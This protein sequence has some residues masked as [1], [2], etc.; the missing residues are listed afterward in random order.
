VTLVMLWLEG[1]SR[2]AWMVSDSRLS[3]PGSAGGRV[4]YT[5]RAAKILEASIVLWPLEPGLPPIAT[6]KLGF[7][8]CG[9][10]LVALNA[11]AA[12]LPLW[13]NLR[14]ST[15]NL[16]PSV[17][18]CAEHLAKFVGAYAREVGGSGTGDPTTQCVLLGYDT[19]RHRPECWCVRT[20][21]GRDGLTSEVEQV[22]LSPRRVQTFGS[23]A[24]RADAALASLPR[25]ALWGREPLR[26]IRGALNRDDQGDVGGGVQIGMAGPD[27]FELLFD[28]QPTV[29]T[30]FGSSPYAFRYRGFELDD[31]SR[32][33][34]T[35]AALRGL[36]GA[37]Y[38]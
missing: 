37:A 18:D 6:A 17:A 25:S 4:Q 36:G 24:A 12:V 1:E 35:F 29:S 11:Y 16:L 38:P 19:T 32:V 2:R 10:S 3:A 15:A 14:S 7:A 8:Y 21:I 30:G 5:D 27:G 34:E 23:G 22:E 26:W 13:S 9:S 31:V 33:G 20:T 28:A